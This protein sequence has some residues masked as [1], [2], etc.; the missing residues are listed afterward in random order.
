VRSPRQ[1]R[2][3]SRA[4]A[5]SLLVTVAGPAL[6]EL[7][8][9]RGTPIEQAIR[10]YALEMSALQPSLRPSAIQTEC[11]SA[12][13]GSPLLLDHGG[14]PSVMAVALSEPLA[15]AA[16]GQAVTISLGPFVY[17]SARDSSIMEDLPPCTRQGAMR[18]TAASLT[19]GGPLQGRDPSRAA[20]ASN[21]TNHVT[22]ELKLRVLGSRDR[23]E[24]RERGRGWRAHASR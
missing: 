20:Q 1:V 8:P 13:V 6:A 2:Q 19:L 3:A 14:G 21:V 17:A 24:H 15:G 18:R 16:G 10:D 23:R 11:P 9:G 22:S 7:V 5:V 4:L 12:N